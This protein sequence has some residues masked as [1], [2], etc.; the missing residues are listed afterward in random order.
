MG[1]NGVKF[2]ASALTPNP[3]DDNAC[4]HSLNTVTVTHGI[5]LP[6]GHLRRNEVTELD[7][8][9]KGLRPEDATILAVMLMCNN[10]LRTLNLSGNCLCGLVG[11]MT[12]KAVGKKSRGVYDPSGMTDLATALIRKNQSLTSLDISDNWIRLDGAR[13]WATALT[14][15]ANGEWNRSLRVL[16]VWHNNFDTAGA[17]VLSDAVRARGTPTKLCGAALLGADELNLTNRLTKE[18]E[19]VLLASDLTF[20]SSSLKTLNL[21]WN[22]ITPNGSLEGIVAA[23]ARCTQGRAFES[24]L[25]SLVLRHNHLGGAYDS[26]EAFRAMGTA[27]GGSASLHTLDLAFTGM[28]PEDLKALVRGGVLDGGLQTLNLEGNEVWGVDSERRGTCDQF[29]IMAL[30]KAMAVTTSLSALNLAGNHLG[31]EAAVILGDVLT[32]SAE[33]KFNTSL[34][35]LLLGRNKIGSNPRSS[36]KVL[37]SFDQL[38][39]Q[40]KNLQR[41]DLSSNSFGFNGC[42][43]LIKSGVRSSSLKTLDLRGAIVIEPPPVQNPGLSAAVY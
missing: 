5:A 42:A 21:S 7:L 35:S 41:V 39:T 26:C 25:N 4:N 34:K 1:R 29:G 17:T 38:L 9:G 32:P 33:G 6:V 10:S 19:V 28:Q 37:Q 14:P 27:A 43:T 40:N 12:G 31:P 16:N 18:E 2:L 22:H 30:A 24:S 11:E 3:D 8:S 20:M 15:K 13:T 23:L 36:P